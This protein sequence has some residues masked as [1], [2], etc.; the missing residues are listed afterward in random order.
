MDATHA[1][2][3][4]GLTKVYNP[5]RPEVAVRA[6]DEV[7]FTIARGESVAIIGP[8][9]GGKSTLMH[10]I[11]C[12]DRPTAGRYLLEGRDVSQLGDDELAATRNRHLGF[13]FQTFNLLPRQT[14]VE[15]VEL[16]LLYA[17]VKGTRERALEALD[18]VGLADRA[19]H[20]PNELSGGQRQRVAIARAVVT[21]PSVL[22]CDE[23]TG[24]LDTQT[25]QEILSLLGELNRDGTTLLVV[26]HD[27][28]VAAH[29][30]RVIRLRDGRI[31][32]DGPASEVLGPPA[33]LRPSAP[34]IIR[35]PSTFPLA[36][37]GLEGGA[38]C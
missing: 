4:E 1:I 19:G 30:S 6:V 25:G 2:I 32:A 20:Q 36:R 17:G 31:E 12:L 16:P 27:L 10:L 18:R 34:E 33:E 37:L 9:G 29:M 8:S 15:N 5:D 7:S 22:L 38:S 35:R 21:R 14:A 13:V 28:E 23:P 24:A 3:A 11:G 26:T